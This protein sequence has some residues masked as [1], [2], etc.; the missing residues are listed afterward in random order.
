MLRA[1]LCAIDEVAETDRS[2]ASTGVILLRDPD[3]APDHA[4]GDEPACI[5]PARRFAV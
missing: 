2:D 5:A 3:G 4:E 1:E